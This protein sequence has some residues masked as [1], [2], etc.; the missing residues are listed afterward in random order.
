MDM[1]AVH[2]QPHPKVEIFGIGHAGVKAANALKRIAAKGRPDIDVELPRQDI[3]ERADPAAVLIIP[4]DDILFG[5]RPEDARVARA[6]CRSGIVVHRRDHRGQI[7]GP[8]QVVAI[9]QCNQRRAARGD[10]VIACCRH[11]MIRGGKKADAAIG[12]IRAYR[13]GDVIGGAVVDDN[14]FPVAKNLPQQRIQRLTQQV[15]D[16]IGRDDDRNLR[17]GLVTKA[18]HRAGP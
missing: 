3:G 11:A 17:V 15:C 12:Q 10:R 8:E 14:G 6:D 16:T 1:A 13:G 9:E 18:V 5:D 7:T 2:Q 4:D